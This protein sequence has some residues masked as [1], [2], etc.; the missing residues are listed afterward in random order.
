M[1]YTYMSSW[2]IHHNIE[3]FTTTLRDLMAI[4]GNV[5]IMAWGKTTKVSHDSPLFCEN[6]ENFC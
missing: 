3:G 4:C 6:K 2:G 5:V 1:M